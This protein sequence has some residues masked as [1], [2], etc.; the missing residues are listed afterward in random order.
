M[1]QLS[2][3]NLSSLEV[4][5]TTAA[6]Y[7][8]A[9]DGGAKSVRLDPAYYQACGSLLT[10]IFSVVAAGE[11]FP[12]LLE[13]SPA[14]RDAAESVAMSQHLALSRLTYYPLLSVVLHRASTRR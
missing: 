5:A 14:A 6:A 11:A 9:C 7:L 3:A 4:T 13:R 10:S 8:D 2:Q 12:D 1:F